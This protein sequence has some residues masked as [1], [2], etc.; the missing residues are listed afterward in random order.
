M[1][2]LSSLL[3]ALILCVSFAVA[4]NGASDEVIV[5][6][7]GDS[8]CSGEGIE[9]FYGQEKPLAERVSDQDWLAHRSSLSWPA[10]L[11]FPGINGTLGENRGVFVKGEDGAYALTQPGNWF[12]VASSGAVTYDLYGSKHVSVNKKE[13]GVRLT[14]DAYLYPQL[15]IFDALDAQG[16]KADYVLVMIGGNDIG[17]GSIIGSAFSQRSIFTAFSRKSTL[18]EQLEGIRDDFGNE[19]GVKAAITKAYRDIAEAAGP[20]ATIIVVGYPTLLRKLSL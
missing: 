8:Y 9:P 18:R 5:V 4:E 14:L 20:R 6:T 16:L 1:K 10:Q 3:L 2:K 11:R 17:F 15:E 7:I 12:F 13:D 19:G